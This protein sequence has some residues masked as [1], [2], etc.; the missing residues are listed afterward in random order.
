MT[1]FRKRLIH[2]VLNLYEEGK[3][4]PIRPLKVVSST[5][6]LE[7]FRDLQQGLHMGKLVVK[8]PE[9]S[10]KGLIAKTRCNLRFSSELSYFLVGGLG[11]IGRAIATWMVDR[12][13]RNLVFFSRSAG[14]T[15]QDQS[16][17]HELEL[18]G[19]TVIMIKGD[20]TALGEVQAAM[21]A[22]PRSIG[23]VL[24]LSM[25]VRVSTMH[26]FLEA[27][28]LIREGP[29]HPRNEPQELAGCDFRQGGW[30]LESP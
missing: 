2:Q 7:A 9:A 12:G 17:L 1:N 6:T 24:Q 4:S 29:I 10:D 18:Q 11:G 14:T 25:I 20:V 23:G 28:I 30:N 5:K 26:T 13:A 16:F 3:I 15:N 27:K 8:M 22:C 21:H 19:C